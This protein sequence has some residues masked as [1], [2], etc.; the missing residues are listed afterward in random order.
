MGEGFVIFMSNSVDVYFYIDEPGQTGFESDPP[1]NC[2]LNVKKL[3]KTGPFFPEKIVIFSK[4]L[5][6]VIFF[7]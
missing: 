3:P 6:M 2:H 1:E 5:S 4:K 7:F